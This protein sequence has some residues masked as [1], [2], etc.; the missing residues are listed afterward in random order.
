MVAAKENSAEAQY[1]VGTQYQFG[2]G[3]VK[4]TVEAIKWYLLSA[5]QGNSDAKIQIKSMY[6]QGIAP[7]EY[8]KEALGVLDKTY[9][10]VISCSFYDSSPHIR[11]CFNNTSLII[12]RNNTSTAYNL[13]SFQVLGKRYNDGRHVT[14]PEN[15]S[16][17]AQNGHNKLIL[18]IKI[19]DP[20]GSTIFSDQVGYGGVISFSNP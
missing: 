16:I 14:F 6:R 13:Y 10:A 9:T 12:R 19:L 7:D 15:F 20:L 5:K 17:E 18:G 4:D 11:G 8:K 2:H 1:I 3:T